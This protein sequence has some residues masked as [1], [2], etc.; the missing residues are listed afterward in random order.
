MIAIT[1]SQASNGNAFSY[2]TRDPIFGQAPPLTIKYNVY[3]KTSNIKLSG[4]VATSDVNLVQRDCFGVF[5]PETNSF[6]IF[7]RQNSSLDLPQL[8]YSEIVCAGTWGDT[9]SSYNVQPEVTL[10]ATTDFIADEYTVIGSTKLQSGGVVAVAA[11]YLESSTDLR[12]DY[13]YRTPEGVWQERTRFQLDPTTP[14]TASQACCIVQHPNGD[15]YMFRHVNNDSAI[16][17]VVFR[18]VAGVLEIVSTNAAFI[19]VADGVNGPYPGSIQMRATAD[20]VSARQGIVLAYQSAESTVL[21]VVDANKLSFCFVSSAS[22]KT[23]IRLTSKWIADTEQFEIGSD[24]ASQAIWVV[25]SFLDDDGNFSDLQVGKWLSGVWTFTAT[26]IDRQ[27]IYPVI[28]NF[29]ANAGLVSGYGYV[30]DDVL[31]VTPFISY[32]VPGV[33]KFVSLTSAGVTGQCYTNR[34]SLD[35][36]GNIYVAG[37]FLGT[38]DFSTPGHTIPTIASSGTQDQDAFFAKYSSAGVPLWAKK[39]GNITW[40]DGAN[41]IVVDSDGNTIVTGSFS[42]TVDFGAKDDGTHVILTAY[43]IPSPGAVE[44]PD[45]FV[46]KYDNANPPNLMWARNFGRYGSEAGISVDVDSSNNI[47][48]A[49][50]FATTNVDFGNPGSPM[51]LSTSGNADIIVL[52][53]DADDGATLWAR[54]WGGSGIDTVNQI[55][56]DA[57]DNFYLI[58]GIPANFSSDIGSGTLPAVAYARA[59]VAKYSGI[60]GNPITTNW[61]KIYS[62]GSGV[63][64]IG[65]TVAPDGRIVVTGTCNESMDFGGGTIVGGGTSFFLVSY[66][67]S[68]VYQW[69]K[70]FGD[71]FSTTTVQGRAVDVAADGQ[72]AVSGVSLALMNMGTSWWSASGQGYFIAKFTSIG[73]FLWGAASNG[74]N[75]ST[76][77]GVAFDGFGSVTAVGYAAGS[78]DFGGGFVSSSPPGYTASFVAQYTK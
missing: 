52:K 20:L 64:A 78:V 49:G 51:V 57:S 28:D 11:G 77:N 13:F 54:K 55:V 50:R 36:S 24:T 6:G 41:G 66:S 59:F 18:E 19:S 38:I 61:P 45:I 71:G 46:A 70:L 34:M 25:G 14:S 40:Q 74:G 2:V 29:G 68:G 42:T 73:E 15:V 72:I 16:G 21:G 69:A 60:N 65:I 39:L 7:Y 5:L 9:A 56:V 4:V 31:T 23:F 37:H 26:T 33:I 75:S 76:A 10:V 44:Q 53:M 22:S 30:V 8:F 27:N 58:G 12:Y 43:P 17:L 62:N 47:L 48:V 63:I 67:S 32:A 1:R 35:S 3:N